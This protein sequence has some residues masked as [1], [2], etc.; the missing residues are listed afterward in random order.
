MNFLSMAKE[1]TRPSLPNHRNCNNHM[2]SCFQDLSKVGRV[3][4]LHENAHEH[5]ELPRRLRSPKGQALKA[6]SILTPLLGALMPETAS[7]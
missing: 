7:C 4:D 1:L 3:K 2:H 6:T 5:F